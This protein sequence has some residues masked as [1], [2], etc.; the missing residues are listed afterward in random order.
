MNKWKELREWDQLPP[1]VAR[2]M[3]ELEM[4][5]HTDELFGISK[6]QN[7]GFLFTGIPTFDQKA[8]DRIIEERGLQGLS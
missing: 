2:K 3:D 5:Q 6:R 7:E 1:S 4:Q 8:W